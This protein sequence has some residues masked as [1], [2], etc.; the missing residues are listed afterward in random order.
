MDCEKTALIGFLPPRHALDVVGELI[1]PSL[2]HNL[3][4]EP[5]AAALKVRAGGP[6][7]RDTRP[8]TLKERQPRK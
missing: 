7:T 5:Y 4:L 6:E 2:W 1:A 8:D 3:K